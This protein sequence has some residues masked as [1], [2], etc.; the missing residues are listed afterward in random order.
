MS[1]TAALITLNEEHNIAECLE[2]VRWA[3]EIVVVDSGSTDRTTELAKQFTPN[4]SHH[5][6][7]NFAEQKN[8]ALSK[9]QSE[10]VLFIDA[11]E[12]VTPELAAEIKQ[13]VSG[14]G[15]M[16]VYRIPRKTYFFKKLL[17]F[18][19]TQNDAP[20][21][22]FPKNKVRFEQP[23][24]E[25]IKTDLPV[26]SL[27]A[28][29]IHHSTRNMEHYKMKLKQYT[30]LEIETM[31]LKQRKV[32]YWDPVLRPFAKFFVL[33]VLQLGILDGFRGLQLAVLSS[34]YDFLK[35]SKFLAAQGETRGK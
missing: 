4:V 33:Y 13:A 8:H 26:Q 9:V 23:V 7:K 5:P 15:E 6:F 16:A 10:W 29:L 3:D 21:R 31:M 12:R 18:S 14:P 11:D 19:G 30:D 25:H 1:I 2:S 22:L 24:H 20:I 28:P 27:K 34:Y 35:Y 32:Y 17:I